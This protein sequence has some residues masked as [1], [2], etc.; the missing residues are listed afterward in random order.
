MRPRL[1]VD[2]LRTQPLQKLLV[3]IMGVSRPALQHQINPV[4]AFEALQIETPVTGH[5]QTVEIT[6]QRPGAA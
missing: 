3:E 5:L 4:A 6:Q 1:N 2:A